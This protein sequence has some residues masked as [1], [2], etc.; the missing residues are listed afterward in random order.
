MDLPLVSIIITAYNYAHM[1]ATAI[2]SAL[3]QDYPNFEV[4]IMD[5]ASTDDTPAVVCRY[6]ADP[7]VRSIRNPENIGLTPNHNAGLREARGQYVSFLSA[8]DWLMPSFVSRAIRY[9]QDHPDVDVLYSGSYLADEPGNLMTFRNM[10]GEPPARFAG[11]NEFAALLAEGCHICFT[12]MLVKREHFERYGDLDPSVKA[13]D[14]EI[15][16]RWAAA[17][18]RFAHDP[19]PTCVVRIHPNQ[20][21]GQ[22]NYTQNGGMLGEFLYLL[23]KY[24]VSENCW[25]IEGYEHATARHLAA[26]VQRSQKNGLLLSKESLT[27]VDRMNELLLA[28]RAHNLAQRHPTFLTIAFYARGPLPLIELTLRSLAALSGDSF[29]ACYTRPAVRRHR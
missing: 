15:V 26:I 8:D 6:T 4:V 9:Y 14:Y 23:Q 25:R 27:R 2:E 17:G 21:S 11:R 18:L 10:I 7:R 22:I 29:E 20:N 28:A 1:V 19:E 5:N 16:I 13:A 12:S 3:G 24:V